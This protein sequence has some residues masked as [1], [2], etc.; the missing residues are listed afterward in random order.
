MKFQAKEFQTAH[1]AIEYAEAAGGC[2]IRMGGK[3]LVMKEVDANRLAAEGAMFAYLI[4]QDGE[5]ITIPANG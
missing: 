1:G 2:A 4:D 3:N 5:I